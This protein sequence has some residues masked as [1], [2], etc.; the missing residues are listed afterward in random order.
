V[1]PPRDTNADA[2]EGSTLTRQELVAAA[3]T[4]VD[5]LHRLACSLAGSPSAA[6]DLMQ[7][8]LT[9]AMAAH[10][11]FH[12]GT[13]LRAWLCRIMRNTFIDER[14]R[15]RKSPVTEHLDDLEDQDIAHAVA[16]PLRGD[17]DLETLRSVVA[18]D[19][20]RALGRLSVDARTVIMLDAEGFT[21]TELSTVLG[22]ATGTVKS[23]LARARA[24]LRAE[25]ADYGRS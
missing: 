16:E 20:E 6:E 19:I 9:R 24:L 12:R 21:E 25:L 15:S 7:D 10:Q 11:Q 13:N 18:G 4:H 22:C 8:T 14:R 2:G 23:R 17:A 1:A 5:A 3:L